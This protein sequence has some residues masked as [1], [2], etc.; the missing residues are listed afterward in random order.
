MLPMM[1]ATQKGCPKANALPQPTTVNNAKPMASNVKSVLFKWTI[2]LPKMMTHIANGTSAHGD[3][4]SAHIGAKPVEPLGRSQA[5]TAHG[6]RKRTDKIE[7]L[8]KCR[9]YHIYTI[10]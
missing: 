7:Y 6:K 8:N 9:H 2:C 5:Y 10:L 3:G 4:K 1:M